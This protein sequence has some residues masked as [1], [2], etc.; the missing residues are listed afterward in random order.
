[1]DDLSKYMWVAMI[2]SKDCAAAAIKD[3]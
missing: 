2:P 1:V 3:I